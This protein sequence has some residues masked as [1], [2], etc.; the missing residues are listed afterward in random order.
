LDGGIYSSDFSGLGFSSKMRNYLSR[1][2]KESF[3][4]YVKERVKEEIR[5]I[6]GSFLGGQTKESREE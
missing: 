6:Q 5:K 3:P 4:D 2:E 1:L